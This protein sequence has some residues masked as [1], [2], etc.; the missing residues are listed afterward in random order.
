MPRKTIFDSHYERAADTRFNEAAARCRGKPLTRD[1][2][3]CVVFQ[4]SM[5]PRPDAAENP[6]AEDDERGADPASMR[7]RPD[8]A[9]NRA[10]R[11]LPSGPL[12]CCFNEAAARC[13]GKPHSSGGATSRRG[14]RFNEAAARC[15]G[16][17]RELDAAES[18]SPASMRPRPDAAENPVAGREAQRHHNASMRPRPD[19]AENPDAG[20]AVLAGHRGFNEAAARC[21]GKPAAALEAFFRQPGLQ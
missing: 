18:M 21:R 4:A 5:R 19:A 2:F 16:K 9:E 11:P 15:R 6:D 10:P 12:R 17:P 7:P 1:T 14:S 3:G 13:R 20:V 8:A